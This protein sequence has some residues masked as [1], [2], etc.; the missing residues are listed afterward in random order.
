MICCQLAGT[1]NVQTLARA[2]SCAVSRYHLPRCNHPGESSMTI[3]SQIDTS[4]ENSH[5]NRLNLCQL[6]SV[7]KQRWQFLTAAYCGLDTHQAWRPTARV[8]A[9]DARDIPSEPRLFHLPGSS[10]RILSQSRAFFKHANCVAVR[11]NIE[12][13]YLRWSFN[14]VN[15]PCISPLG[16]DS[17]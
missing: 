2:R 8:E 7:I 16:Q 11:R 10:W 13:E 4:A 14:A 5:F 9:S 6:H 15:R 3:V 17:S 12:P 1:S